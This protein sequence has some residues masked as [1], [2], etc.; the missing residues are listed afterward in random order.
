MYSPVRITGGPSSAISAAASRSSSSSPSRN[1]C[2]NPR[3]SCRARHPAIC[4]RMKVSQSG[5]IAASA[6]AGTRCTSAMVSPISA[7]TRSLSA[8]GKD[9]HASAPRTPGSRVMT[10][11]GHPSRSPSTTISG[12][13]IRSCPRSCASAP[14]SETNWER[15]NGGK[16]FR[17][18][19]SSS[20]MTTLVP[21]AKTCG[22]AHARPWLR[23]ISSAIGSHCA[24]SARQARKGS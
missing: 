9:G 1:F 16:I 20:A 10:R 5:S 24:G 14:R 23:A 13:A 17:M 4:P 18:S 15:R 7:S 3:R 22:V 6:P 19:F 11:Y 8:S 2:G 12:I 21:V